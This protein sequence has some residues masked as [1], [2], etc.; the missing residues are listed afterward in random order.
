MESKQR[1]VRRHSLTRKRSFFKRKLKFLNM[2][3]WEVSL[4]LAFFIILLVGI[5]NRVLYDFILSFRQ[6]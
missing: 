3:Y 2:F 5:F 4:F 1:V 6:P